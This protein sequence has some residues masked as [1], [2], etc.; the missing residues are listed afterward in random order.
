[1]NLVCTF[2]PLLSFQHEV[3]FACRLGTKPFNI[4]P[5]CITMYPTHRRTN[6]CSFRALNVPFIQMF[7]LIDAGGR[8]PLGFPSTAF[9]FRLS[10]MLTCHSACNSIPLKERKS[11]LNH[12]IC[13]FASHVLKVLNALCHNFFSDSTVSFLCCPK[14][15]SSDIIIRWGH[16]TSLSLSAITTV[17]GNYKYS[18]PNIVLTHCLKPL[19]TFDCSM[20]K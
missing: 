13:G 7:Y 16:P 3:I 14:V 2:Y 15:R 6:E 19:D 10:M 20:E 18:G 11:A 17:W 5:I 12:V 4:F 8:G 9:L 1:M